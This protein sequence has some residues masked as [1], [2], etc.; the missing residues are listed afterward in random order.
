MDDAG[1]IDEMK[2]WH[3][4]NAWGYARDNGEWE[5]LAN[6]FCE[7]A[8][9]NISW[10]HAP[11]SEFVARSRDMS[12]K[13]KPGTHSKHLFS[14]PLVRI[15]AKRAF[16]ICHVNLEIRDEIDGHMVD[17]Q[18]WA[19][20]FDLLRKEHDGQWR[21][22]KR[23]AVYEKDRLNLVDPRGAP[24]DLFAGLDLSGYLPA[25]QYLSW[26]IRRRMGAEPRAGIVSVYSEQEQKLKHEGAAWLHGE[27]T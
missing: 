14:S 9:I 11:A 19:R 22:Y 2:I 16:A 15:A 8:I 27:T 1:A 4:I 24:A 20:F 7:D 10:I 25:V 26:F 13:R 17:L 23:T 12:A 18:A 21:I 5:M 6:C 3:L